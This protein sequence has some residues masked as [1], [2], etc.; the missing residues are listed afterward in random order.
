MV[1]FY[2]LDWQ[3]RRCNPVPIDG[4][5]NDDKQLTIPGAALASG[6][7]Y[8]STVLTINVTDPVDGSTLTNTS[9]RLQIQLWR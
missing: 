6:G 1:H 9:R 8:F 7:N 5:R 2:P 3:A 4:W